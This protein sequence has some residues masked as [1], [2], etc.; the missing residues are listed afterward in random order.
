MGLV[1]E[2][3]AILDE[4][5]QEARLATRTFRKTEKVATMTVQVEGSTEESE[6][7]E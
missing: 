5:D 4:K 7:F 6:E 2:E 3:E 1:R